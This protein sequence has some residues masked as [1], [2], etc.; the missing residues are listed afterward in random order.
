MVFLSLSTFG[1][2]GCVMLGAGDAARERGQTSSHT[3]SSSAFLR[4]ASFSLVWQSNRILVRISRT[5]K[6]KQEKKNLVCLRC[7]PV[8]HRSRKLFHFF[9][10]PLFFSEPL[11]Q[12][13]MS[14]ISV[15]LMAVTCGLSAIVSSCEAA[16]RAWYREGGGALAGRYRRH[17]LPQKSSKLKRF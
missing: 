17:K 9:F 8:L 3:N 15:L 10:P 5:K 11:T 6:K 12:N 1:P 13:H 16:A 14:F 7:S 4:L 2:S